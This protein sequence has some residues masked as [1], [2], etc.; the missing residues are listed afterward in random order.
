MT[1]GRDEQGTCFVT[2]ALSNIPSMCLNL[3][4]ISQVLLGI[5][6]VQ[7][8]KN[9]FPAGLFIALR[10]FNKPQNSSEFLTIAANLKRPSSK[11]TLLILC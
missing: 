8:S 5:A 10:V 7:R 1:C 4:S 6:P 2:K 9:T 11:E 3:E